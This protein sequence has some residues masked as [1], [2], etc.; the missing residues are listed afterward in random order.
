MHVFYSSVRVGREGLMSALGLQPGDGFWEL[1]QRV[2][3]LCWPSAGGGV[4]RTVRGLSLCFVLGCISLPRRRKVQLVSVHLAAAGTWRVQR[5]GR[6]LAGWSS[7]CS[8][9]RERSPTAPK[10]GAAGTGH[11][12]AGPLRSLRK[13][14]TAIP[15]FPPLRQSPLG[16]SAPSSGSCQSLGGGLC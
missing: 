1:P 3:S 2:S 8:T 10:V 16:F 7:D 15:A 14:C 6:G 13:C 5:A 11:S 12:R 4:P 9:T